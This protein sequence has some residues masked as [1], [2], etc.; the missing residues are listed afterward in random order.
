[1]ILADGASFDQIM[2]SLRRHKVKQPFTEAFVIRMVNED[3]IFVKDLLNAHS[4]APL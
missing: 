4:V 2:T 3:W 1:M